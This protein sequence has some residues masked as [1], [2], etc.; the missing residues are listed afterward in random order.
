VRDGA[1]L[2]SSDP[3]DADGRLPGT[4]AAWYAV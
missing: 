1:V 4:T 3:L 2:L